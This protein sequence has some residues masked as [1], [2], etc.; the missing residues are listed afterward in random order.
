[1]TKNIADYIRFDIGVDVPFS[2]RLI[3]FQ[4]DTSV[5]FKSDPTKLFVTDFLV[6]DS[7]IFNMNSLNDNP[8]MGMGERAGDLFFKNETGGIH[9]RWTHDAANPIDNGLP[10]GTNMYGFQP[11]YVYQSD[12]LSWM[13]VFNNNPYATDFIV[14]TNEGVDSQITTVT[15][16]GMIEKYFFRGSKPDDVIV[17]FS[18][19]TGM[20]TMPPMWAFGWQQCRFGWVTDDV[21]QW[22]VDQYEAFDLPIDTMWADIDYM[23]DYK[24]F[25]IS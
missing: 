9:S 5:L 12:K 21:W 11:F 6:F 4:D 20:P 15:I 3:E 19:L 17:K 23:D 10:P 14:Y 18:H 13:G 16:G 24:I 7:G 25:T 8:L 1:M 2:Y 22:V